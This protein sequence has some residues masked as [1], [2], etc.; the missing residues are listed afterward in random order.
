MF[1]KVTA[2]HGYTGV[3][4]YTNGLGHD[5]IYPWKSKGQHADTIKSFIDDFG[6]PQTLISNRALEETHG[7]A[8]DVY[9]HY[10]INMKAT[11]PYSPW[12]N[13]AEASNRE[14]KKAV[15]RTI[16][17]T[18]TPYSLWAYCASYCAAIICLT[19]SS[20]PQ[21]GGRTPTEFVEGSTPDILTYVMFN[22]YQPVF[23]Y[24][25][26]VD[27]PHHKKSIGRWIG[28]A[29]D[30]T[31]EMSYLIL[32]KSGRIV[33]RKSVWS[34]TK[35]DNSNP[36]LQAKLQILDDSIAKAIGDNVSDKDSLEENDLFTCH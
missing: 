19:S 32:A 4:V 24:T 11:V 26:T 30:C 9:R 35:D 36:S 18:N 20:I 14:L 13:R 7:R 8:R 28:V 33:V 3:S 2:L 15:R 23:Y 16:R 25:P 34:L 1:S 22:W 29:E 17:R 21:L 10:R 5:R 12:Q 27:H 6:V 31:D